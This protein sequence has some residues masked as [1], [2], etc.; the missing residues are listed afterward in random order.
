MTELTLNAAI[1]TLEQC[2]WGVLLF[3]D[4]GELAWANHQAGVL[5]GQA[6]LSNKGVRAADLVARLG[7]ADEGLHRLG[8][9][10]AVAIHRQHLVCDGRS[11]EAWYLSDM[12]QLWEERRERLQL[13]EKLQ[14]EAMINPSTG[15]LTRTSLLKNLDLLITRSRRY[16]NPVSLIMIKVVEYSARASREDVLLAVGHVLRDQMRWVDMVSRADDDNFIIVLPETTEDLVP[17]LVRKLRSRLET[18]TVPYGNGKPCMVRAEFGIAAWR[19]GDDSQLLLGRL[20]EALA[21]AGESP[22]QHAPG[23]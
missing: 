5:L 20:E 3:T 17:S 8:E 22:K 9:G 15:L 13:Q 14:Q 6:G 7:S 16:D 4:S 12:S 21:A 18:L 19:K 23:R 1:T 11:L 10:P 2:P